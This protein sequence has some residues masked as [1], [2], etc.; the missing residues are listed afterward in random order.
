ML[1]DELLPAHRLSFIAGG[2]GNG[3]IAEPWGLPQRSRHAC[4]EV[5]NPSQ[6][7]AKGAA[8]GS[9][10]RLGFGTAVFGFSRQLLP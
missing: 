10:A 7:P 8:E 3:C 4:R 9:L 5:R 1:P 6:R 2:P